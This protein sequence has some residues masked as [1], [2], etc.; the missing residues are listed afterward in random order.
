MGEGLLR[1]QGPR[2]WSCDPPSLQR[3]E[4][5]RY[6]LWRMVCLTSTCNDGESAHSRCQSLLAEGWESGGMWE[7]G[8]LLC[9]N[10]PGQ[11]DSYFWGS[12]LPQYLCFSL[13]SCDWIEHS[14][15]TGRR[16]LEQSREPGC[17]GWGAGHEGGMWSRAGPGLGSLRLYRLL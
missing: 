4:K 2:S 17:W 9:L 15:L 11:A 3:S 10:G 7:R 14:C 1:T 16:D 12:G 5:R 6:R 13:P 8:T